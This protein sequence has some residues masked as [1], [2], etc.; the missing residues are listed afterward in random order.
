MG[1]CASTLAPGPEATREAG[2]GGGDRDQVGQDQDGRHHN[3]QD[4][5]PSNIDLDVPRPCFVGP[6]VLGQGTECWDEHELKWAQRSSAW[7]H[8]A[9]PALT[10]LKP[11]EARHAAL[12]LDAEI[13]RLASLAEAAI[14]ASPSAKSELHEVALEWYGI[15]CGVWAAHRLTE[16]LPNT[17]VH[18]PT[19]LPPK[20]DFFRLTKTLL[21]R[22][23]LHAVERLIFTRSFFLAALKLSKLAAQLEWPPTIENL[24]NSPLVVNSV[25]ARDASGAPAPLDAALQ[26]ARNELTISVELRPLASYEP[27]VTSWPV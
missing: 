20:D 10:Q 15:C 21:A 23:D 1:A 14:L 22:N 5:A 8:K 25:T 3:G 19:E 18:A 2:Q 7:Y 16:S 4:Q 26:A 9:W 6:T 13:R 12:R 27:F 17:H 24:A 11:L